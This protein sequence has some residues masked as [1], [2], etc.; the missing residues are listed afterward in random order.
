MISYKTPKLL[1]CA[2]GYPKFSTFG[3]SI[4]TRSDAGRREFVDYFKQAIECPGP[5]TRHI[6]EI[7][8]DCNIFIVTGFIERDGGTLYCS[9]GFFS[10]E[11]GLVYKRRKV[12]LSH[13]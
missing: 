2:L 8:H 12:T 4:G 3:A 9:V 6:E 13:S 1:R 10:P 11:S 7:A 5:A